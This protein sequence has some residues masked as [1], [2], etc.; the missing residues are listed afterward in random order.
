MRI[1][2]FRSW[3]ILL[4]ALEVFGCGDQGVLTQLPPAERPSFTIV[5]PDSLT[6]VRTSFE[7]ELVS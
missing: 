5:A 1:C 6:Y 2:G 7:T 3:V 4:L